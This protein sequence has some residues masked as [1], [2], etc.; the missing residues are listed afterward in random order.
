[1]WRRRPPVRP[2]GPGGRVCGWWPSILRRHRAREGHDEGDV[3]KWR[4][5]LVV[6]ADR[7]RQRI[8]SLEG[9]VDRDTGAHGC[10]R[11]LPPRRVDR[12]RARR[13]T[14]RGADPDQ[15]GVGRRRGWR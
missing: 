6:V 4:Q 1:P 2:P 5:R 9:G 3:E 7:D 14:R 11:D 13:R 8:A 10:S 12:T 15:A